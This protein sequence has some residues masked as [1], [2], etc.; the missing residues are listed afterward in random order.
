V[1]KANVGVHLHSL[2]NWHCRKEKGDNR[3]RD[4]MGGRGKEAGREGERRKSKGAW[5]G[6]SEWAAHEACGRHTAALGKHALL[7]KTFCFI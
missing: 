3:S 7:S 4:N 1:E 6:F 2:N 5:E